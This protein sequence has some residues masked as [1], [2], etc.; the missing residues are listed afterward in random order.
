MAIN[1]D[2]ATDDCRWHKECDV[3]EHRDNEKSSNDTNKKYIFTYVQYIVG[4]KHK[5]L[6]VQQEGF[7]LINPLK[8]NDPYSG[9]TAS[10]TSKVAFYVFIQQI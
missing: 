1:E 2:Q 7:L 4:R 6:E 9:R 8:P 5:S 3:I 10:L